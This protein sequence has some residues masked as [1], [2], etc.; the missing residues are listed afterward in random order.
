MTAVAD[1]SM[2]PAH[3]L[4]ELGVT[5]RGLSAETVRDRLATLRRE[6]RELADSIAGQ[7]AVCA[8][9][10]IANGH[11]RGVELA[12]DA[13]TVVDARPSRWPV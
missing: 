10:L 4:H 8:L 1:P 12:A 3:V 13:L 2:I 6:D 11:P 5:S 9:R 7:L